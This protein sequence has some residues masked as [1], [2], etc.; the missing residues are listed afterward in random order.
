MP[1]TGLEALFLGGSTLLSGLFGANAA[2]RSANQIAAGN[3]A[4]IDEQRRQFDATMALLAPSIQT[5]DA[6][7][8]QLAALFGLPTFGGTGG[9]SPL[10]AVSGQTNA[11]GFPDPGP[12]YFFQPGGGFGYNSG[13][14]FFSPGA[15]QV[16]QSGD[17][18]VID[19]MVDASPG[20]EPSSAT[21]AGTARGIED[22]R[23]TVGGTGA[24]GAPSSQAEAMNAFFTSPQFLFNLETQGEAIEGAAAARGGALSGG[25]L[26]ALETN[27]SNLASGEFQ[28]YVNNLLSLA[29]GG[30][31][32]TGQAVNVT[33]NTG[34]NVGNLLAGQGQARA[35]G[36]LGETNTLGN[37]I[38]SL[39]FIL[40]NTDLSNLF[41][42]PDP[43]TY[44]YGPDIVNVGPPSP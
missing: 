3:Q 16:G 27:A 19:V 31:S 2:E 43:F 32:A 6:A 15:N 24:V 40:G 29:T 34:T 30:A 22:A 36:I 1:F 37:T 12:S 13:G 10:S 4:A 5:G 33:Q 11:A 42:S 25:V 8:N 26:Q 23:A 20:S 35:S 7:R 28:N 39:G 14:V 21:Q 9:G 44:T 18:D 41:G 17:S 38:N